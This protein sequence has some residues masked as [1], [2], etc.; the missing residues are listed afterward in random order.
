MGDQVREDNESFEH[1]DESEDLLTEEEESRLGPEGVTVTFVNG[2]GNEERKEV[3]GKWV[4]HHSVKRPKTG[5]VGPEHSRYE[6]YCPFESCDGS[7]TE[8]TLSGFVRHLR[9]VDH[10]GVEILRLD[11][12]KR[13]HVCKTRSYQFDFKIPEQRE[14]SLIKFGGCW[15]SEKRRYEYGCAVRNCGFHGKFRS[16][17]KHVARKHKVLDLPTLKGFEKTSIIVDDNTKIAICQQTRTLLAQSELMDHCDECPHCK[18]V[19]ATRVDQAEWKSLVHPALLEPWCPMIP[20]TKNVRL[21]QC[22]LCK[23]QDKQFVGLRD[24]MEKHH[25]TAHPQEPLET[26]LTSLQGTGFY[27]YKDK[28]MTVYPVKPEEATSIQDE[29]SSAS[30]GT[31]ELGGDDGDSSLLFQKRSKSGGPASRANEREDSIALL[32]QKRKN[33]RPASQENNSSV[34][35]E[36]IEALQGRSKSVDDASQKGSSEKSSDRDER[37]GSGARLSQKK[38]KRRTIEDLLGARPQ[39]PRGRIT[40]DEPKS[41]SFQNETNTVLSDSKNQVMQSETGSQNKE[42]NDGAVGRAT[43][44]GN[45]PN[46]AGKRTTESV[47]DPRNTVPDNEKT[48]HS[49]ESESVPTHTRREAEELAGSPDPAKR[50]TG[51]GVGPRN[52]E[53]QNEER[54]RRPDSIVPDSE[55]E[56]AGSVGSVKRSAENVQKS[57][58][59]TAINI[60]EEGEDDGHGMAHKAVNMSNEDDDE[61]M[62]VDGEEQI[63]ANPEGYEDEQVVMTSEQLARMVHGQAAREASAASEQIEEDDDEEEEE[64]HIDNTAGIGRREFAALRNKYDATLVRNRVRLTLDEPKLDPQLLPKWL[65]HNYN[66]RYLTKIALET[67]QT[68]T[69]T[70]IRYS[71]YVEPLQIDR[72]LYRTGFSYKAAHK[73]LD[74]LEQGHPLD[75]VQGGDYWSDADLLLLE[76]ALYHGIRPSKDLLFR[77][78][79]SA[80]IRQAAIICLYGA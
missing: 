37:E 73:Y 44:F 56:S 35:E 61:T 11:V 7:T 57:T 27:F 32:F 49:P 58:A 33:G 12:Y 80:V 4:E 71:S 41:I 45:G 39:T 46:S 14:G 78:R 67:K 24:Q 17:L 50:A 30:S 59:E 13:P 63:D 20:G 26:A 28:K 18:D 77:H 19:D 8:F 75:R 15:D 52:T 48:K 23:Q 60:E 10:R 47:A 55:E 69:K 70:H 6:L 25:K 65:N 62:D 66:R 76:Q 34:R 74:L 54:G 2:D 51:S 5:L 72:I 16:V 29:Y 42:P 3:V 53:S 79:R 1:V 43:E 9:T 36:D 68:Y 64:E 21:W 40:E 22:V 31:L 38:G